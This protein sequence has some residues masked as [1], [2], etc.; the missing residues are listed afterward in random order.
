MSDRFDKFWLPFTQDNMKL[1]VWE[2]ASRDRKGLCLV[3]GKIKNLAN[4]ALVVSSNL[5]L[6]HFN[7]CEN[8]I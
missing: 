3:Y 2:I 1:L 7:V 5:P 4:E 6:S 8:V